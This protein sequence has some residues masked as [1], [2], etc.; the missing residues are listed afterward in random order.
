MRFCFIDDEFTGR[1]PKFFDASYGF[2]GLE[3]LLKNTSR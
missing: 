1:K 2:S 3:T